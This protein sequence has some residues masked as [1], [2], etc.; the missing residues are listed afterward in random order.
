MIWPGICEE[1]WWFNLRNPGTL[2]PAT[3]AGITAMVSGTDPDRRVFDC[4]VF[5]AEVRNG[6]PRTCNNYKSENM[7]EVRRHLKNRPGRGY[8]RQLSFLELCPTCNNDFIDKEVFESQHGYRGQLC[9]N[10][11]PQRRGTNAQVQWELLY[12]QV[13][14]AKSSQNLPAR[15]L[16]PLSTIH[17]DNTDITTQEQ[18]EGESA[19]R[20][21]SSS[22]PAPSMSTNDVVEPPADQ[23]MVHNRDEAMPYLT[24]YQLIVDSDSDEEEPDN[25]PQHVSVSCMEPDSYL[26]D[27]VSRLHR[28]CPM[29]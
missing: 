24:P 27:V 20:G 4:P 22:W 1:L 29:G 25:E 7:A 17:S 16:S 23:P 3:S 9:N 26:I 21:S 11:Q 10:R 5:V 19:L 28:L 2:S 14:A 15:T 12:R 18:N 13:E 6:W 8:E